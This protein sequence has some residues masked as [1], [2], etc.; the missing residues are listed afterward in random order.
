ML[1][2]IIVKGIGGFYYVKV[3]DKI[4]ECR[5]RGLFRK[6]K[7]TPL[8][9]DRVKIRIS[10]E[11]NTGF[12]EE[13]FERKTELF[14]PPVANVDQVIIVFAV[15][16]PDPNLWLLDRFLLLA[17][18]KD[19]DIVICFNKIDLISEEE[20][21]FLNDVYLKAGY[22]VINTS[23]VSGIG[24]NE[25][26]QILM[27]KITVFAGPSGVGK[28]TLL[29]NI[30]P[31]LQ[32]KTGEV[33]RKT[34]RGKH[35]TRRAE[36]LELNTGGW[37]VDTPGFSSLNI[38]FMEEED[39]SLYFR[40]INEFSGECRFV[41]CRHYKEPD[42]SVKKA[43]EENKISKTRYNNYLMF[44]EELKKNRRY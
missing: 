33:S 23:C 11:D 35:T 18:F 44:L 12:I 8:V 17:E 24:I 1:E 6:K 15:K 30:Q 36:L 7:I 21:K 4:Y 9:G 34:N 32:L 31:D 10:R 37:V 3:D 2:G 39:L 5:A 19:L 41:G 40:E 43:V 26:R 29:N 28:S 16:N 38:D 14:R 13:I 27:N 20:L 25:L 22:K 42:C